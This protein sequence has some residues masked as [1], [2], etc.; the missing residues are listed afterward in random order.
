MT[1]ER[2]ERAME[3]FGSAVERTAER[4]AGAVDRSV[5]RAW[6]LRPVRIAGKAV[7]LCAGLGLMVGAASLERHGCPKAARLCLIAGGATVAA[8]L[9]ETLLFRKK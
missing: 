6:R 1:E 4:A 2:F 5:N 7:S 3:H 9:V 8:Q